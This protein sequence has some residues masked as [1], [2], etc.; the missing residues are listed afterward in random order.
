VRLAGSET[1][2]FEGV[3]DCTAWDGLVT[4]DGAVWSV[5]PHE[6]AVENAEVHAR[7]GDGWFDLGPATSGSLTWCGDAAYFVRDPQ[8]DK[9]PARLMRWNA[10]DGLE[11]VYETS[12]GHAFLEVPRCGGDSITVTARAQSGDEQVS[13]P[14]G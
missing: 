5:I 12:G 7:A 4:D 8:R 9:D 10:D 6:R 3:P 14:A 11:T 2:P 1:T 13:A